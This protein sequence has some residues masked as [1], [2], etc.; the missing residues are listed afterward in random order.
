MKV[1]WE[2]LP[3]KAIKKGHE[4]LNFLHLAREL[5]GWA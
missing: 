4:I 2:T 1:H 5:I 3:I